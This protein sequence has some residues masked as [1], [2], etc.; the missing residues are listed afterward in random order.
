[1]PR[2]Q[3]KTSFVR[4]RD[5]FSARDPEKRGTPSRADVCRGVRF[6]DPRTTVRGGAGAQE[7]AQKKISTILRLSCV[8][9]DGPELRQVRLP[10]STWRPVA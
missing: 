10:Q 4:N 2:P 8:E 1:M 6:I 3:P 5:V 9:E 7:R